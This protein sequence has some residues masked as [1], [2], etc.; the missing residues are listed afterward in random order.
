LFEVVEQVAIQVAEVVQ[1]QQV[2]DHSIDYLPNHYLHH[3]M[4]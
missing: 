3:Q 4:L 1:V 2:V